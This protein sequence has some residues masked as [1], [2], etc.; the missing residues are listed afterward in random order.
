V[1]KKTKK[2]HVKSK[3]DFLS[4][5]SDDDEAAET[6][7]ETKSKSSRDSESESRSASE[8]HPSYTFLASLRSNNPKP[9]KKIVY[10]KEEEPERRPNRGRHVQQYGVPILK[11]GEYVQ[12]DYYKGRKYV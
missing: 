12:L 11:K 1:K 8:E 7:D 9:Y 5:S 6:D 4:N 3:Y 10:G 2:S